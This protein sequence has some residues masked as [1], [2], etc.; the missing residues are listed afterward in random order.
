MS[1]YG[2]ALR[3]AG[4]VVFGVMA[5]MELKD[6]IRQFDFSDRAI[7]SEEGSANQGTTVLVTIGAKDP[8]FWVQVGRLI[9][10][11]LA[12]VEAGRLAASFLVSRE[13]KH[14]VKHFQRVRE[15]AYRRIEARNL[16]ECQACASRAAPRPK[17]L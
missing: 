7:Q 10:I 15:S 9:G 12:I 16:R 3:S 14:S 5:G 2:L 6:I 17:P 13:V 11:T 8:N 1:W 4:K